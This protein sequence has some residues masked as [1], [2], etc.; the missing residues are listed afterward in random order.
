[1]PQNLAKNFSSFQNKRTESSKFSK[2]Q[3]FK[4]QDR[5]GPAVKA[6]TN[7]AAFADVSE[8]RGYYSPVEQPGHWFEL[9]DTH[10]IKLT[11]GNI[12]IEVDVVS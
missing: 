10:T 9:G 8:S 11:D 2:T 12:Q 3:A 5:V 6:F 7:N 4:H 1:M